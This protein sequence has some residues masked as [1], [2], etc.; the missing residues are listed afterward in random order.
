[1][2]SLLGFNF[3]HSGVEVSYDSVCGC[4][5]E[6][7]E[8]DYGRCNVIQ[9]A[10]VVGVD[11]LEIART[12]AVQEENVPDWFLADRVLRAMEVYKPEV[13]DIAVRGGYYGE[14]IES[15]IL[16]PD[17]A[18][19]VGNVLESLV[20]LPTTGRIQEL[21]NLEYG[22]LLDSLKGLRWRE[23]KVHKDSLIFGAKDHYQKLDRERLAAYAKYPL[24]KG[25][26]I[27][28]GE[29][30]KVIDGYHRCA[31][32]KGTLSVFVGRTK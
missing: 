29:R 23:E 4:Y 22:Y 7:C 32:A 27:P 19:N 20:K 3:N 26:V 5:T 1:M 17:L 16:K 31:A 8:S 2:N 6:T 21:L 30:F 25:C 10:R 14:E 18:S 13:W 11:V 24:P 28:D 12:L 15:V 9:N